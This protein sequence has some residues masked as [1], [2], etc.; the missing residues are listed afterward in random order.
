MTPT[1]SARIRKYGQGDTAE[2][3][4]RS[5]AAFKANDTRRANAAFKKRSAAAKKAAATRKR[6]AR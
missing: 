6:N 4:K 1:F 5:L 2:A 3:R